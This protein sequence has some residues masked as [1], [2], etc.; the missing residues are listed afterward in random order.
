MK[1][2]R[3]TYTETDLRGGNLVDVT[4]GTKWMFMSE[5]ERGGLMQKRDAKLVD[6]F[7]NAK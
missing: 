6:H 5:I 3:V 4:C 2:F 7:S 1:K